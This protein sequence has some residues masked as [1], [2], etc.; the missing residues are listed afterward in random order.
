MDFFCKSPIEKWLNDASNNIIC[1]ELWQFDLRNAKY[2]HKIWQQTT[3]TD[4]SVTID[5]LSCMHEQCACVNGLQL[6]HQGLN[7][8][9]TSNS[10]AFAFPIYSTQILRLLN[11]QH[12]TLFCHLN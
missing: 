6:S 7:D 10:G 9:Q 3:I 5:H 1:N 2:E 4:M 12:K 11:L 8:C